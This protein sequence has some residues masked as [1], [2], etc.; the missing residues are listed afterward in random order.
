MKPTAVIRVAERK[1]LV[2]RDSAYVGRYVKTM[3]S[4]NTHRDAEE[5]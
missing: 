3:D 4:P 5:M 1:G 2:P